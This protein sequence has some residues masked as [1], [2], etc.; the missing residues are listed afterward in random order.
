MLYGA[1]AYGGAT[2][3]GVVFRVQSDGSNYQL[4]HTFDAANPGNGARPNGR[5]LEANGWLWGT[6]SEGGA[7]RDGTVFAITTD[8]TAFQVLHSFDESNPADGYAP[9]GALVSGADGF[10]YG[11]TS[12]GGTYGGGTVFRLLPSGGG[13]EVV[14]S[15]DPGDSLNSAYPLSALTEGRPLLFYGTAPGDGLSTG[16]IVF[17]IDMATTPPTFTTLRGF[18]PC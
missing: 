18:E 2:T 1:T 3:G 10:L 4:L 12:S 7:H 16:G 11:T 6:T 9:F 15:F 17:T 13:F 5:L 14:H 8:G